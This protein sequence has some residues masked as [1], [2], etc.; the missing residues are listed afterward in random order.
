[1][2]IIV[3]SYKLSCMAHTHTHTFI[4]CHK[5]AAVFPSVFKSLVTWKLNCLLPSPFRNCN[6][7]HTA[8]IPIFC[9]LYNVRCL[10]YGGYYHQIILA[11]GT[12]TGE[13]VMHQFI[14]FLLLYL[15]K[16]PQSPGQ[17]HLSKL[18]TLTYWTFNKDNILWCSY[19]RVE[20]NKRDVYLLVPGLG[21]G[22][23]PVLLGCHIATPLICT[24]LEPRKPSITSN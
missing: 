1:M 13:L 6:W 19:P 10:L 16:G 9:I 5:S 14:Q 2:I 22:K 24:F 8:V 11:F 17:S 18:L 23:Q 3:T 15:R 20:S 21:K 4:R 12:G 7:E